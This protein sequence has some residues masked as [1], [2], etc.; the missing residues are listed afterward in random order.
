MRTGTREERGI[1]QKPMSSTGNWNRFEPRRTSTPHLLAV[2]SVEHL[3]D[4]FEIGGATQVDY[5]DSHPYLP[6]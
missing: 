2:G 6:G 3:V 4:Y 1:M 5:F